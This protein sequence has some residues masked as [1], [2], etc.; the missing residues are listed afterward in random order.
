MASASIVLGAFGL[1]LL[2]IGLQF[3]GMLMF[4]SLAAAVIG[5]IL[6]VMSRETKTGKAGMIVS[7]VSAVVI[8]LTIV[9]FSPI[10]RKDTMDAVEA[11]S[12]K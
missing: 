6:G 10:S 12:V 8:V 7:L 1:L 5:V 4:V 11:P 3:N 2:P 9:A